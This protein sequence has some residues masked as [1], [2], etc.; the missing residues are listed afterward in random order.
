MADEKPINGMPEKPRN[1]DQAAHAQ[2]K[3]DARAVQSNRDKGKDWDA[4][5]DQRRADAQRQLDKTR[6]PGPAT[7]MYGQDRFVNTQTSSERPERRKELSPA[8]REMVE[9]LK[10]ARAEDRKQLSKDYDDKQYTKLP[11]RPSAD[12]SR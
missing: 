6:E 7:R 5:Q 1:F 4:R 2:E 3:S 9:K 8:Q 11:D 12:R 10:Q